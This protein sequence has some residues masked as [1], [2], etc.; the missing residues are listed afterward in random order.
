VPGS[1]AQ[2]GQGGRGDRLEVEDAPDRWAPRVSE[3]ERERRGEVGRRVRLGREGRMGRGEEKEGEWAGW[4]KSLG[5]WFVF[6]FFFK[7]F[8]NNFSKLF[9]NQTLLHLFHNCFHKLF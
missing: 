3:R 5:F 2:R 4:G 1:A 7:S 9:Y 6:S 8:L